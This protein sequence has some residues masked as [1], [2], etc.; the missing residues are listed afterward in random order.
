MFYSTRPSKWAITWVCSSKLIIYVL[1]AVTLTSMVTLTF[2]PRSWNIVYMLSGYETHLPTKYEV[3]PSIGLG[4]VWGQTD[5]HTHRQRTL[6]YYNIDSTDIT[7]DKCFYC[8]MSHIF[9]NTQIDV[10]CH[11]FFKM[12]DITKICMISFC[13]YI[14]DVTNYVNKGLKNKERIVLITAKTNK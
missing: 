12:N 13:C 7:T 4:G 8:V 14:C 6:R 11:F 9:Q 2:D 3:N 1:A 5:R 10:W